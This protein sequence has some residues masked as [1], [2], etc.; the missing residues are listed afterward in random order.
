VILADVISTRPNQP[1]HGLSMVRDV[2]FWTPEDTT[3]FI[4][5]EELGAG[6]E[7]RRA[8]DEFRHSGAEP[9]ARIPAHAE[10][11]CSTVSAIRQ[12]GSMSHQRERR[13]PGN[14]P[15]S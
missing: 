9:K 2:I 4:T 11:G 3:A 12:R 6:I 14:A 5:G 1:D 8:A 13:V 7:C 15:K 10:A